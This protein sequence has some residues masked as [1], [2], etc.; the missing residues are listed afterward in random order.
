MRTI[1][2]IDIGSNSMRLVIV[3]ISTNNSYRI[4]DDVKH[5]VRL[6]K[7]MLPNGNLHPLRMQRAIETLQ[8]YKTLCDAIKTDSIIVVATEAIRKASNQKEFLELIYNSTGLSVRVLEGEE[9]AYYDYFSIANS[10]NM[11]ENL[12]MDI[13]GSSTE[14]IWMKDRKVQRMVS[15][16]FGTISISEQ[17]N[18]AKGNIFA[19]EK[20]IT[21]KLIQ[22][23]HELGWLPHGKALIGIGG[24]FRNIAKINKKR[25]FYPL[26]MS[27]NYYLSSEN[28]QDI[29]RLVT[30]TPAH[31]RKDIRGLSSERSDIIWGATTAINA[32]I[33]YCGIS[34]VYVS[35][36]GL[37]EGVIFEEILHDLN[38]V[39][40]VL[41]YSINNL[42][43]N[44]NLNKNHAFH[45]WELCQSLFEQLKSLHE[46]EESTLRI[47]KTAALLH[48]IG[49]NISYYDH[50]LHSFY[51]ILNSQ[52]NGLSQQEVLMAAYTAASHRKDK[53][54]IDS[55]HK[56][57]LQ[58]KEI[59]TIHKLGVM[60]RISEALDR[61]MNK[62]I[63]AVDCLIEEDRV[64]LKLTSTSQHELES[65]EALDT[66]GEFQKEFGKRLFVV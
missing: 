58:E 53:V 44:I 19:R 14:L 25:S 59:D 3:Q 2:I 54:K 4:I 26:E 46:L 7:D 15:L 17:L 65:K 51:I 35:G 24:S 60:L 33:M 61:Q 9:E 56:G 39:E 48:D 5:S 11:T 41:D 63:T 22:T 30:N 27:H 28:V 50:H 49:I 12:I 62:N 6:G 13:G 43:S 34:D 20:T 23:Y 45:V 40:D 66:S 57:I 38:P 18:E 29:H 64:T 21:N 36:H 31:R 32:L 1:G 10:F 55:V 8:F 47:L 52:I 37:R 16:P 42:I